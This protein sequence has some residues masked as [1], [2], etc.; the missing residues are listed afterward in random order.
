MAVH[1]VETPRGE[2]A[3]IATQPQNQRC[4]GHTG[5]RAKCMGGHNAFTLLTLYAPSED[6]RIIHDLCSQVSHNAEDARHAPH[7]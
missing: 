7:F 1:A 4:F 3:V 2:V 5:V 6:S